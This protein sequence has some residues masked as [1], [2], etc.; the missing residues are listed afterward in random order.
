MLRKKNSRKNSITM[1]TVQHFYRY[2]GVGGCQIVRKKVLCNNLVAPNKSVIAAV[3]RTL[4]AAAIAA[5][6]ASSA[7][8]GPCIRPGSSSVFSSSR[9]FKHAALGF[10]LRSERTTL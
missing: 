7:A 3:A 2:E 10:K 1:C 6:C 9:R 4:P 5:C 8:D